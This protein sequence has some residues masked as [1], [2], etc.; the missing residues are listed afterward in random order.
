M[1]GVLGHYPLCGR[2]PKFA[3]RVPREDSWLV[4]IVPDTTWLTQVFKQDLVKKNILYFAVT[5]PPL[6][7]IRFPETGS[8]SIHKQRCGGCAPVSGR[9]A[10]LGYISVRLQQRVGTDGFP[11]HWV[12]WLARGTSADCLLFLCRRWVWAMQMGS[13]WWAWLTQESRGSCSISP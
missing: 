6:L 4:F 3:C 9:N 10:F 2:C 5:M 12:S 13:V 8:G 1:D 11:Q 7:T